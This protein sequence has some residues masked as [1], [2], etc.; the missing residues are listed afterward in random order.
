[1]RHLIL[2]AVLALLPL[3]A[4]GSSAVSPE[5]ALTQG[6][7]AL[8]A[9]DG[10]RALPLLESAAASLAADPSA[11]RWKEIQ[12][13]LVEAHAQVDPAAARDRFLRLAREHRAQIQPRDFATVGGKL[14]AADASIALD[15]VDAGRREFGHEGDAQLTA[16]IEDIKRRGNEDPALKSKLAGLGYVGD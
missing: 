6:Y 7:E 13:A 8:N 12:I 10:A 9:G 3:V 16:L 2:A 5:D 15:V 1:M 4:C 14:F 11:P